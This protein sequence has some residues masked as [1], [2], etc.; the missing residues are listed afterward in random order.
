[1]VTRMQDNKSS[2]KVTRFKYLGTPVVKS[3]LILGNACHY[4]V[5]QKDVYTQG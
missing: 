1:M 4:R 5:S 2:E 3:G